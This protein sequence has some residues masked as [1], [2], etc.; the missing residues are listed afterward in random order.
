MR[1]F[2]RG[3]M[4]IG[5]A[6]TPGSSDRADQVGWLPASLASDWKYLFGDRLEAPLRAADIVTSLS[7]VLR[8]ERNDLAPEFSRELRRH[9]EYLLSHDVFRAAA[10]SPL[11][12]L[13][14]SDYARN[15]AA[16]LR[17]EV[18]RLHASGVVPLPD[19]SQQIEVPDS[20][21]DV[22]VAAED[23]LPGW[24][25]REK[26]MAMARL[27]LNERPRLCV[28]VGVYGGRSLVPCAAAL[29]HLGAG[30]IVGVESWSAEV[31]VL[32][33]TNESNDEWWKGID[34]RP[35]KRAFFSFI[36]DHDLTREI[37]I[38]EAPSAQA[39]MIFGAIDFLHIDGSH[40]M[41][42]AAEDVIR[43]GRLVRPG[44]IIVFDDA[45]WASTSV[46]RELLGGMATLMDLIRDPEV[47][48]NICAVYRRHA[49]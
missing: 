9:H 17:A 27:V 13:L 36:V 2:L 19:M 39:A 12:D 33:P 34:F 10:P 42:A 32:D 24:C 8:Q 15:V 3:I 49:R 20:V 18:Q 45:N 40:A 22:I 35:I 29:R 46:A 14:L 5:N 43:Y 23:A 37:S 16:A 44:G 21:I 11:L 38:V 41:L 30:R 47:P 26:S 25:H 4:S 48:A 1:R 7:T 31:A 28:E 6:P